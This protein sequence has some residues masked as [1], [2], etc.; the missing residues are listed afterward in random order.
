MN[1]EQ[2]KGIIERIVTVV[3]TYL[4]A[5]GYVPQ[6]LGPEIVTVVIGVITVAW[7]WYVNT[8][9]VLATAADATK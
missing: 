8:P 9:K 7:G 6:A 5:K 1:L 2:V 3:I 4:V